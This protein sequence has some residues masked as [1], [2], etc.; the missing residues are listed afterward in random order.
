[1]PDFNGECLC[2]AV[3]Y[4]ASGTIKRVSACYCGQCRQQ[5]GG[6]AFHGV[7]LEGQLTLSRKNGL[8]WYNSSQKAERGFCS[9]CGSSLF[10]RLKKDPGVYDISMG[11]LD[12]SSALV[13]DAHIFVDQRA[14]YQSVPHDAPHFTEADLRTQISEGT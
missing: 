1:M 9:E 2:G 8:K 4:R 12:D 11:T 14:D 7:E 6:G 13:I 3:S 5:N 10:W